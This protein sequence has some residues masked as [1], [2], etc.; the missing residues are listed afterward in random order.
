MRKGCGVSA[1]PF[2]SK[3]AYTSPRWVKFS[4]RGRNLTTFRRVGSPTDF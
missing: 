2:G 4:R 3:C 1:F